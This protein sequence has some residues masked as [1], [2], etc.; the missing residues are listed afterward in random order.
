MYSTC[1]S[2]CTRG[3][4]EKYEFT[5]AIKDKKEHL[6]YQQVKYKYAENNAFTQIL[7]APHRERCNAPTHGKK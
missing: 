3:T 6:R 4:P 1:L 5:C 7:S 2:N